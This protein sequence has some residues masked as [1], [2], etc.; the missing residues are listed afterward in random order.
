MISARVSLTPLRSPRTFL[1]YWHTSVEA[2]IPARPRSFFNP[3]MRYTV[4]QN[5]GEAVFTLTGRF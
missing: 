5:W 1:L 3:L 2:Q 4:D